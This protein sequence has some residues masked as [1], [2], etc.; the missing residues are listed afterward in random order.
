MNDA[1]VDHNKEVVKSLDH[2]GERGDNDM[3]PINKDNTLMSE[4][5][6]GNEEDEDEYGPKLP[7]GPVTS[8]GA[9]SGPTIPNIQDL[10][11]RRG[12]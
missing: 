2:F 9:L 12:K 11:L 8:R 4:N 3:M 7:R 6:D 10:E 1:R 5:V